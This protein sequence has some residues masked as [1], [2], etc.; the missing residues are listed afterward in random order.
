MTVLGARRDAWAVETLKTMSGSSPLSL[1]VTHAHLT[2]ARG[3]KLAD[4]LKTDFRLAQHFMA[5]HDF[6]EGVRSYL[7]DKDE[8]PK[9]QPATL[10]EVTPAMVEACFGP[11]PGI[12]D[13]APQA[14]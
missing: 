7:I 13:W 9:W 8:A 1:K 11:V 4:V 12:R 5:G 2:R 14:R 10:A 3:Q 6:F